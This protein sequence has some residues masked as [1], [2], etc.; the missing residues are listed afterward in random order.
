MFLPNTIIAAA[1]GADKGDPKD[2]DPTCSSSSL[3]PVEMCRSANVSADSVI[4]ESIH[5]IPGRDK[6]AVRNQIKAIVSEY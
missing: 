4:I 3:V 1:E 6:R 2:E 5:D